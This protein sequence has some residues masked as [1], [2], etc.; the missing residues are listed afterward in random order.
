MKK[1]TKDELGLDTVV[2]FASKGLIYDGNSN[3]C[4]YFRKH[5]YDAGC[6]VKWISPDKVLIGSYLAT[7]TDDIMPE[8]DIIEEDTKLKLNFGK[9]AS[10]DDK[11]TA[12][13]AVI[14]LMLNHIDRERTD[15]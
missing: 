4:M 5:G 10:A 1:M 15:F 2:N 11:V 6:A 12:I 14:S 3:N 8:W 13:E 7:N 9:K